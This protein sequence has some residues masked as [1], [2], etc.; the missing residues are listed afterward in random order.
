MN[1][2]EP[3]RLVNTILTA[4]NLNIARK[5]IRS[6]LSKT[7]YKKKTYMDL[8]YQKL[9]HLKEPVTQIRL[10]LENR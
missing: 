4:Q 9:D 1:I 6:H 3:N 5:T 7:G 10:A 2:V 8:L